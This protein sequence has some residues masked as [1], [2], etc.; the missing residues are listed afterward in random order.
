MPGKLGMKH[1][2]SPS[3]LHADD[4]QK[5]QVPSM[6]AHSFPSAEG[7]RSGWSFSESRPCIP[8]RM[9]VPCNLDVKGIYAR[10]TGHVI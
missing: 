4:I 3:H 5:E 2:S 7:A 8:N 1:V 6:E 10:D 9:A